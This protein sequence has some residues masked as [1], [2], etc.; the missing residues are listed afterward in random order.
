MADNTAQGGSDT[1]A[2]DDVGGVK[3]QRVKVALGADGFNDGDVSA[4]NPVPV[5]GQPLVSIS[6]SFNRPADT[7]AYTNN[8]VISN[9]TSAPSVITFT[10]CASANGRGGKIIQATLIDEGGTMATPVAIDLFIFQTAPTAQNDNA[11]V[12][13]SDAD[14]E[15]I[16]GVVPFTKDMGLVANLGG[17]RTPDAFSGLA[18]ECDAASRDLYGIL[19]AR[20]TFS[21]AS[22]AKIFIRLGIEQGL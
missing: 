8:D 1:I 14:A 16:L 18:F 12:N 21:P 15:K 3:F 9:S 11:G 6:A 22:A 10:N 13:I 4:A 17:A 7:N 19:V 2:T 5:T 20:Q